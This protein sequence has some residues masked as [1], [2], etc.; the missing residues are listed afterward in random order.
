[1]LEGN[2]CERCKQVI[3]G[4]RANYKQTRYCLACAKIWKKENSE[5]PWTP[6]ERRLYMRQYMRRYRHPDTSAMKG[7][8]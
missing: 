6:E 1:M 2:R 8:A 4:P 3:N 7:V 5:D